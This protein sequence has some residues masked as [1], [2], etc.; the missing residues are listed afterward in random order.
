MANVIRRSLFFYVLNVNYSASKEAS[1]SATV[2][3]VVKG[4]LLF[5]RIKNKKASRPGNLEADF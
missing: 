5:S 1:F 4:A 3:N 2:A